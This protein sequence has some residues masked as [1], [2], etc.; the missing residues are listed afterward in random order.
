MGGGTSDFR[1]LKSNELYERRKSDNV[2]AYMLYYIRE[3]QREIILDPPTSSEVS[4]SLIDKF[5]KEKEKFDVIYRRNENFNDRDKIYVINDQ[6]IQGWDSFGPFPCIENIQQLNPLLKNTNFRKLIFIPKKLS[7][8]QL[9]KH[10]MLKLDQS[11]I[12]L[13]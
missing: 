3:D 8:Y 5:S 7:F 13:L 1:V 11:K 12:K 9:Y 10:L 2:S 6:M 4:Q